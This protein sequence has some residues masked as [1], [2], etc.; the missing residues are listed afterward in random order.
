MSWSQPAFESIATVLC[1]RTGLSFSPSRRQGAEQGIRRAMRRAGVADLEAYAKQ[2][3][4]QE[5]VLDDLIVEL[6]VGETYFFREPDQFAFLR[7]EV[8]PALRAR[9]TERLPGSIIRAWSAGCASGEE[10]YSLAMLFDSEGLARHASVLAT[11]ISQA[12]L[13][14]ARQGVYRGWSLRGDGRIAGP[15]LFVPCRRQL[16]RHGLHSQARHLRAPQ[17][18]PRRLP[19]ACDR[20]LGHGPG[21]LPQRAHLFRRGH[22]RRR[23]TAAVRRPCSGGMALSGVVGSAAEPDCAVRDRCCV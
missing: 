4:T 8:L 19:V 17:S 7:R 12:A 13:A 20:H 18:C 3:E 9:V 2:L 11:D 16:D 6:T 15:A 10:A 23:G 14:K 21:L 22:H 5:S 1:R